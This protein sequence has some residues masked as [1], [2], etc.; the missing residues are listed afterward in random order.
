MTTHAW[1]DYHSVAVDVLDFSTWTCCCWTY[2]E[3]ESKRDLYNIHTASFE[4]CSVADWHFDL[5]SPVMTDTKKPTHSRMQIHLN[6]LAIFVKQILDSSVNIKEVCVPRGVQ[7]R[8]NSIWESQ[9]EEA[10]ILWRLISPA[11]QEA[12]IS[13]PWQGRDLFVFHCVFYDSCLHVTIWPS[14]L[15]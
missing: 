11:T 5:Q 1:R 12:A 15:H 4:T 8:E 9:T 2:T 3:T 14:P 13:L 10:A 7:S 6:T